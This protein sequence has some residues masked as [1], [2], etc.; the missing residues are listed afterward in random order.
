MMKFGVVLKSVNRRFRSVDSSRDRIEVVP[1]VDSTSQAQESFP[2][3][4]HTTIKLVQPSPPQS[5]VSTVVPRSASA[6]SQQKETTMVKPTTISSSN[7]GNDQRDQYTTPS[8]KDDSGHT[9]STRPLSIYEHVIP[10]Q[11]QADEEQ[12]GRSAVNSPTL[13]PSTTFFSRA[14]NTAGDDGS[15]L[16]PHLRSSGNVGKS[17]RVIEKITSE[18]SRLHRELNEKTARLEEA[19]RTHET[20]KI[21]TQ[22]AKESA[23]RHQHM[24]ETNEAILI[25]RDR[26]VEELK[27]SLSREKACRELAERERQEVAQTLHTERANTSKKLA[28]EQ[29]RRLH[30]QT[31]YEILE[32][33]YKKGRM[34]WQAQ[35]DKLHAESAK[36]S[37]LLHGLATNQDAIA[38]QRGKANE[39]HAKYIAKVEEYKEAKKD[40]LGPFAEKIEK[41]EGAADKLLKEMEATLY[42]MKWVMA[43]KKN[44]KDS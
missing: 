26:K 36:V 18:N 39:L 43:V 41:N 1:T 20:D 11:H 3:A 12:N 2:A 40:V 31:Q 16:P 24:Y 28:L 9:T 42:K 27:E 19:Q 17:G 22:E 32:Q 14:P 13:S 44:A 23:M 29:E 37:N 38:V 34:P 15:H 4:D 35:I 6:E 10:S 25:R 8:K 33:A 7:L 21:V 5:A 30:Y